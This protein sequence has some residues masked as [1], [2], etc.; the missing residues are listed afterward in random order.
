MM[1]LGGKNRSVVIEPKFGPG[2]FS[3]KFES[4]ECTVEG[5]SR[6]DWIGWE[7]RNFLDKK[8]SRCSR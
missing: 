1:S 7:S 8:S 6:W 2:D 4:G 3:H 5:S